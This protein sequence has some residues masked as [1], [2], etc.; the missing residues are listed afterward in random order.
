[1]TEITTTPSGQHRIFHYAQAG[2]PDAFAEDAAVQGPWFFEPNDAHGGDGVYSDGY[3]TQEAALDAAIAWEAAMD[4]EEALEE[5]EA[6]A[7][8]EV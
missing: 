7:A 8:E 2:Q 5:E 3:P 1:M 6:N 4:M